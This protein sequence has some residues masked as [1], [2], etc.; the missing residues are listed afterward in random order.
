MARKTCLLPGAPYRFLSSLTVGL[1]DLP[2]ALALI[3]SPI[4]SKEIGIY[5]TQLQISSLGK[6][7]RS[8]A[9]LF[10]ALSSSEQGLETGQCGRVDRYS[11]LGQQISMQPQLSH[12]V[13]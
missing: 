7:P 8:L 4:Q 1:S 2:P 11:L 9:S 5:I 10:S 6:K 12:L 13:E 3:G